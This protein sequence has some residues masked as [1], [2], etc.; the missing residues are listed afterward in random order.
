MIPL[1]DLKIQYRS[2]K[3]EIHA[4]IEKVLENSSFV[5]GPAVADFG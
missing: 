2:I 4:A 1:V 3:A 5:L